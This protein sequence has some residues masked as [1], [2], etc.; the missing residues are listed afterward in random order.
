MEKQKQEPQN[1]DKCVK[2]P[3][4]LKCKATARLD[5]ANKINGL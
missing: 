3:P 5:N 4:G 1:P 2:Y